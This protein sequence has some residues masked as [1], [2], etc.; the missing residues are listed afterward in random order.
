[1]NNLLQT[2]ATVSKIST[3]SHRS[4]RIQVDTAEN[5]SDEQMGKF[6]AL[7]EKFGHFLFSPDTI[8]EEDLLKLPPL[9]ER[10]E[11]GKSPSQRLYN[12]LFVYHKQLND[13]TDFEVFYRTYMDKIINKIKERLIN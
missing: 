13:G 5:L 12:I 6:S 2:P 7:H 10:P 11:E 1:M 3:L 8:K 9:P 4:L